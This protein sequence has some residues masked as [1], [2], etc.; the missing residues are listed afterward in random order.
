M[1]AKI[2]IC[3]MQQSNNNAP[4]PSKDICLG[5]K[6][7]LIMQSADLPKCIFLGHQQ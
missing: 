5:F 3:Y 6:E 4:S 1:F 2:S 7:E